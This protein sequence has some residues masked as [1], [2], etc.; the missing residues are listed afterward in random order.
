MSFAKNMGK[1]IGKNV[2]KN[3]SQKLLD[4]AKQ[5]ALKSTSKRVIQKTA[6]AAVALIVTKTIDL[7]R[8]SQELHQIIIQKQLKMK[9]QNTRFDE[10][11]PKKR[12]ISPRERQEIIDDL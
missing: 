6:E 11:I 2:S 5:S 4:Y 9:E 12:C 3:Y 1:N 8:K 7:T 10:A